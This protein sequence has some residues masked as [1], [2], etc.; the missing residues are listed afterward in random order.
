MTHDVIETLVVVCH[1]IEDPKLLAEVE[2]NL[3]TAVQLIE[4]GV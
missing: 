1:A 3:V 2:A 4:I